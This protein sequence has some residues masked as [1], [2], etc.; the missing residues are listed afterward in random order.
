MNIP[1]MVTITEAAQRSKELKIGIAKNH[2]RILCRE[3]TIPC[4]KIGV[5]TLINWDGL[6][7]YL[8]NPTPSASTDASSNPTIR[9]VA[10]RG[11][12]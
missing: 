5:K 10:E 11:I 8:N 1:R 9:S 6:L 3:G 2:I 7:N 4:C 12:S